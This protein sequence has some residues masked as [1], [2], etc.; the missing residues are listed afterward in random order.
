MVDSKPKLADKLD[1]IKTTLLKNRYPMD[2]INDTISY[3]CLIFPWVGNASMQLLEQTKIYIN[4]CS[5]SVK[6]RVVLKFNMVFPPNLKDSS[7]KKFS[8]LPF[9]CKCDV[10]YIGR[11]IQ[12]L[13]IIIN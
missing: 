4:R 9:K 1:F 8:H 10:Y 2:V 13:N 11:T 7:P 6:L 5:N 12:C 3:K